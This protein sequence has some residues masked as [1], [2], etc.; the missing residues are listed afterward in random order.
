MIK[1]ILILISVFS[2]FAE[3]IE[4]L[5]EKSFSTKK[6]ITTY[7]AMLIKKDLILSAQKIVYNPNTHYL[8]ATGN[9]Y[10][11]FGTSYILTNSVKINVKNNN[12]E[13]KP[14]FLF[15]FDNDDW[16]NSVY[17]KKIDNMYF[18]TKSIASTCNVN[19]PDWK[20]IA[21]SIDYNK[22]NKWINLYNP[23]LYIKDVPIVYLPYLGFSLSKQRRSGFLRPIFGYSADE[24]LLLTIP[25]YQ[26]LGDAADLELDPTIRTNRGQGLYSTFR[27]VHSPTSFGKFTI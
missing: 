27:F 20:I 24:G 22:N 13:A 12:L 4:I 11:N 9:V 25:Y 23:T 5:G 26:V 15:N 14:F 17:S 18:S 6:T 1:L 2:L 3:N 21:T 19:H 16:I 7:N 8:Y 10:I